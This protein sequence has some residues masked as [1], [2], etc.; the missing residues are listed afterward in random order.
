MVAKSQIY[1]IIYIQPISVLAGCQ[2]GAGADYRGLISPT[3]RGYTCQRWD[4][5]SPHQHTRNNSAW[6]PDR[7]LEEAGNFCRN[8]YG[9]GAGVWCYTSD[10]HTRWDYCNVTQCSDGE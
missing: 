5:Q 1:D 10:P 2:Y 6:F 9:G 4:T 7:T 3:R 8:P